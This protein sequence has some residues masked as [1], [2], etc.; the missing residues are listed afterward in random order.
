M[1]GAKYPGAMRIQG[2]HEVQGGHEGPGGAIG[3]GTLTVPCPWVR[4]SPATPVYALT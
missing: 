2:G 4:K 3:L 1:D